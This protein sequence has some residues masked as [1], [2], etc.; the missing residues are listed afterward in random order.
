MPA[1][2]EQLATLNGVV[3]LS[4]TLLFGS[5]EAKSFVEKSIHNWIQRRS[6]SN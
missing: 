6:G 5:S 4:F 2:M 1:L 3:A